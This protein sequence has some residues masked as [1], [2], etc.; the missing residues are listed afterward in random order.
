VY[1]CIY[2]YVYMYIRM[3]E[4]LYSR[5]HHVCKLYV[6]GRINSMVYPVE[7]GMEDWLYA[8]GWD[9]KDLREKCKGLSASAAKGDGIPSDES[10]NNNRAVVMLVETSDDKKPSDKTLGTDERVRTILSICSY[11]ALHSMDTYM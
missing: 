2:V 9:K 7:G 5:M 3:H 11:V 6:V 10:H 4:T 1:M 8:A